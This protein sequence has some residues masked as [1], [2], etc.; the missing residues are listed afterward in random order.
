MK[1]KSKAETLS[2]LINLKLRSCKIPKIFYFSVSAYH[3]NRNKIINKVIREFSG[4]VAIRSSCLA[5]DSVKES[6]AGYFISELDINSN[7]ADDIEI[8]IERVVNSYKNYENPKN[9]V[10]IQEMVSSIK[11]SGVAMT[12]DK[13]TFAPYY[14][15]D[16][17]K[18]SSADAVTSGLHNRNKSFVYF[19]KYEKV[20]NNKFVNL[21]IRFLKEINEKCKKNALDVEFAIDQKN[22]IY[23]LQV[24]PIIETKCLEKKFSNN[25]YQALN[26]LDKKIKKLQSPHHS[27][28]GKTTAFGSMPDW[29]PAEM[30]G[31]HPKPLALSIYQELITNT[32]WANQR[33]SYGYRD[34]S[35]NQ[36]MTTFLGKPYIDIRVDFNSW[37]PASL[38][39]QLSE[40]LVNFYINKFKNNLHLHDKVEFSIIYTSFN[41]SSDERI[42]ELKKYNFSSSEIKKITHS[43][44][45][46]TN[47]SFEEF[48]KN[49]KSLNELSKKFDQVVKSKMYLIDKIYWF[50][51]DCKKYGTLAFA[52]LARCGFIGID[53]LNSFLDKQIITS[54]EKNKFLNSI[55]TVASEISIDLNDLKKKDFIKKY[56]H[57][58]PSTYDI[59]SPNYQEGYDQYFKK[60]K[61]KKSSHKKFLFSKIQLEK[62]SSL[63]KGSDINLNTHELIQF[64]KNS[65]KYREYAKYLFSRN[66]NQILNLIKDLALRNKISIEEIS[67]VEIQSILKLYYSLNQST[68]RESLIEQIKD[69]KKQYEFNRLVKLPHN[70]IKSDDIFFYNSLRSHPNFIGDSIVSGKILNL[71][72]NKIDNLNEKIILIEGADPGYDFIFTREIIGLVTKFGGVNSHMSIRCAELGIP[73]AIGVGEEMYEELKDKHSITIDCRAQT[74]KIIS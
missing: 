2:Q 62:I 63:L 43:L 25:I 54:D 73:A 67:Y 46:I 5:E 22:Q 10:L 57:L 64:I 74:I 40:K 53:F 15:V 26:K 13:D 51:E 20:I 59:N 68:V 7:N 48:E 21:I 24:R 50:A 39:D 41:F 44:K 3:K 31:I 18:S 14:V 9:L 71:N 55:E 37:I 1:F 23:L 72:A 47:K 45:D 65:I 36:L 35:S 19:S 61:V 17:V 49:I 52:G 6:M 16:Y 34:L 27:L 4:K 60:S 69:N 56:G 8:S 11:Y 30:I 12:V 58:R 38:P 33:K 29:N 42:N 32:V 70:I 66:I 28:L